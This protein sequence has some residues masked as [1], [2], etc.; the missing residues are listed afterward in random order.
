MREGLDSRQADPEPPDRESLQAAL[1]AAHARTRE[2]EH[3]AKNSLQLVCSLLQLLARRTPHEETRAALKSMQ[4]RISAVAAVH[5]DFMDAEGDRFDLT[6][7]VREQ[8]PA[9]ARSQG[10]E[11]IVR[12]DLDQ[13]EVNPAQACPLALIVCELISNALKHGRSDG[14]PPAATVALRRAGEGLVLAVSDA[15]PGPAA[16]TGADFGLTMVRLLAQQIAGAFEL[17]DAHPGLRAVVRAP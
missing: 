14:E 13:V 8:A 2:V 11:A 1:A 4:Q 7:F 17:E 5:R 3:R 6:R 10:E 15:G 16:V 9:L 12:L